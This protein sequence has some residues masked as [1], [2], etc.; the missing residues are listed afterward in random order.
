M[1]YWLLVYGQFGILCAAKLLNYWGLK[2]KY[3]GKS[4]YADILIT[5][6]QFACYLLSLPMTIVL[7][8]VD[9]LRYKLEFERDL[10]LCRFVR[11][12]QAVK[13]MSADCQAKYVTGHDN[14]GWS[15]NVWVEKGLEK[16]C[17]YPDEI[18]F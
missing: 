9:S 7:Y 13:D 17:I 15:F 10:K 8:L 16:Y 1:R 11:E 14:S 2:R 3:S 5:I 18:G 6:A 12:A 4:S